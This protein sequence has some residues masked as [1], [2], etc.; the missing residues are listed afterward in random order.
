MLITSFLSSVCACVRVYVC[1]CVCMCESL[2]FYKS[3][4]QAP[5]EI[6]SSYPHIW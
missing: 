5:S 6:T 1:V 3:I 4:F 2:L